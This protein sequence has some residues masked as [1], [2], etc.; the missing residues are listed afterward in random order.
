IA[1]GSFFLG[2]QQVFPKALQGSAL[3]LVLALSPLPVMLF[4]LG[5][6]RF[7]EWRRRAKAAEMSVLQQGG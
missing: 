2:Q 6:M 4:W 7:D 1:S 5:K 3:L